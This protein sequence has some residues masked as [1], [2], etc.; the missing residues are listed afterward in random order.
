MLGVFLNV[1]APIFLLALMGAVIQRTKHLVIASVN[2]LT[3]YLFTPALLFSSLTRTTLSAAEGVEIGAV[4]LFQIGLMLGVGLATSRIAG[5]DRKTTSAFIL[6][7]T[8]AN[9]GNYGLPLSLLAF[10][11]PGLE[12][13][14]IYFVAES[15]LIAIVAVFVA[16]RGSADTR[17]SVL[18]VLKLP[19]IYATGAALL[20]RGLGIA[21]PPLISFPIGMAANASVPLM[22]VLLGAQLA[23]MKGLEAAGTVMGAAFIR[24]IVSPAAAFLLVLALGLPTATRNVV[25]LQAAMPTAVAVTIYATEFGARPTFVTASVVVTTLASLITL[26]VVLSLLGVSP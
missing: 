20:L 10:G 16:S 26:T 1:V 9:N 19:L 23:T 5:L 8:F 7:V 15:L 24:L 13:A 25:V 2:H 11:E 3:V 12:R 4:V 21:V 14:T 17:Q 6:A 18:A 22:L